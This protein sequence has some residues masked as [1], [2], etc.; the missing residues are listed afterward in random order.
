MKA[1]T[2]L[3]SLSLIGIIGCSNIQIKPNVSC[4]DPICRQIVITDDKS[5]LEA[6][7]IAVEC[8]IA[9]KEQVDCYKKA[10]R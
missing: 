10:L 8:E 6:L 9:T 3:L 5:I 1:I 4:P 2:I 7:N